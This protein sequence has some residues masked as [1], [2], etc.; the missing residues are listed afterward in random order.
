MCI[1]VAIHIYLCLKNRW[2]CTHERDAIQVYTAKAKRHHE[3]FDI[4]ETGFFIDTERPY[5]G[6][7]PDSIITCKCCGKGVVEV[8]C[9]F[10]VKD[11]LL[12]ENENRAGFCLVKENERWSLKRNHAY[13]Y[14]IQL[15]MAV[16]RVAYGDFVV[17]TE[18]DFAIERIQFDN[19]FFNTHKD[20]VKHFYIYG[21]LPELIGKFY[22]R[23]PIMNSEG[24]V[25]VPISSDTPGTSEQA[26]DEEDIT[27]LWCYCNEPSFGD[28]VKCDN[29][30]CTIEWF[31]FDCLRI[32]CP[33][34]GKWYCPSCRKLSKFNKKGR[35][36]K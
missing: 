25:P 20:A 23:K 2:G 1:H 9:P 31:H 3:D 11:G 7:S 8:K 13:Y 5:L 16:C 24:V 17:W 14:Q 32:R 35:K 21:V 26:D 10:C 27:R 34:K 19:E 22:T 15:Q 29:D 6:A 33:P 28:M 36:N 12:N 30:K 18:Q 4:Q